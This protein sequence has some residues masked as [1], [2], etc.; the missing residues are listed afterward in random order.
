[1]WKQHAALLCDLET[2]DCQWM[3]QPEEHQR[4]VLSMLSLDVLQE[5]AAP[6]PDVP[7]PAQF[8]HAGSRRLFQPAGELRKRGSLGHCADGESSNEGAPDAIGTFRVLVL[9]RRGIAR[10]RRQNIDIV[11]FGDL[12]R[13]Q[14][15][16][17]L[18]AGAELGAISGCDEG[19][20]H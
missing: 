10:G 2:A 6:G 4:V 13:Q 12:L 14:P 20:L 18:R 19:K 17:V 9:P 16:G 5:A 8:V 7:Y 11:T 15:A 1:M 3:P